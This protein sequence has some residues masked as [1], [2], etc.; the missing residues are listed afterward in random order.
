MTTKIAQNI[1]TPP[2]GKTDKPTPTLK[3]LVSNDKHE[4]HR[5]NGQLLSNLWSVD[6]TFGK[7]GNNKV[8]KEEIE[9]AIK[10]GQ[11]VYKNPFDGT[12]EVLTYSKSD[13]ALLQK[14]VDNFDDYDKADNANK[15]ADNQINLPSLVTE[16]YRNKLLEEPR[17]SPP[18]I[19]ILPIPG[20][21]VKIPTPPVIY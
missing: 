10:K 2:V 7:T 16:F 20:I 9:A 17:T 14:V 1:P 3:G 8:L 15:K 19:P 21:D 11:N 18:P 5:A 13:L 4:I 6:G 12:E